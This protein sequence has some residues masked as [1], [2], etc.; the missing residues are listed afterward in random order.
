MIVETK[1]ST[2]EFDAHNNRYRKLKPT[3]GS[4]KTYFGFFTDLCIGKK[5]FIMRGKDT[6]TIT[7]RVVEIHDEKN[8]L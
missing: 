7:S 8:T 5:A 1:N 2:Y 6:V 4:W 3:V